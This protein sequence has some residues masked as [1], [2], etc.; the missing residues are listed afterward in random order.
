MAC[1]AELRSDGS[2]AHVLRDYSRLP[3]KRSETY[4]NFAEIFLLGHFYSAWDVN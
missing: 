4:F 1:T 2:T 3:N